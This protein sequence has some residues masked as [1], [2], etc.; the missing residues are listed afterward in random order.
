L[1]N[2]YL[3][4]KVGESVPDVSPETREYF[5]DLDDAATFWDAAP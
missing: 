4:G 2:L 5:S 1:G 3:L